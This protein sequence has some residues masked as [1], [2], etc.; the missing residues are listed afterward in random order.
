MTKEIKN[1]L[2]LLA[3]SGAKKPALQKERK[4][5]NKL[6]NS[7]KRYMNKNS[8]YYD[9]QFEKDILEANPT[10][11]LRKNTKQLKDEL[12]KMAKAGEPKPKR[13]TKNSD[14]L[15]RLKKR[16]PKF[17]KEIEKANPAWANKITAEQ[18]KQLL[19]QR[20]KD[21][22]PKPKITQ[23][24]QREKELALAFRRYVKKGSPSYDIKF[25]KTIKAIAPAWLSK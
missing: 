3:R 2:L 24:N 8:P 17:A 14:T 19:I 11:T 20:A 5:E 18:K 9:P 23:K 21:K 7:L 12:L 6:A 25:V 10:W 16:D 1:E 22:L 4:Y 15:I 13:K